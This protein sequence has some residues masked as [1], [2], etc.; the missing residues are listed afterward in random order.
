[1]V[2]AID[3]G[4]TYSGWAFSFKHDFER[5]PINVSAKTWLGGQLTSLKGAINYQLFIIIVRN[6]LTATIFIIE[7]VM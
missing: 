1:M 6:D 7:D 2:A 4:T 5:D 3:F